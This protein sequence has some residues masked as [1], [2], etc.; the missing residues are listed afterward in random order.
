MILRLR[1]VTALFLITVLVSCSPSGTVVTEEI[2]E[3]NSISKFF[4]ESGIFSQSNTGFILYDPESGQ[5]IHEIGADR[6]Y[7]PA[8]NMKMFTL[9]AAAKSLPDTLPSLLYTVRNDSLF[10]HGTADPTFLNPDFE[11]NGVLEFLKA[12]KETLVYTDHLFADEHFGSGWSWDWYP[13]AYAPEKT[14]FPIY[15]NMMRMQA[16]QISLLMLDEHTP[17]KPKFF[18]RFIEN[19][20]WNGNQ[21]ELAK[22]DYQTNTIFYVPKSDTVA[23]VRNIPFKYES[24]FFAEMLS[25]TLGR[26]VVMVNDPFVT[27][28]D[29]LYATPADTLYRSMMINSDNFVA[30]QLMLMISLQQ[31]GKM[32][33]EEAISYSLRNYFDSLTSQ[34]QW[35]DGSGLT[36]YNLITP[37]GTVQLLEMII[38]KYGEVEAL[39][40]FP[41]GGVSGTIQSMYRAPVGEQPYVYAKTGT[42]S[43][44][45]ALSGYVFTDSGRRLSFSFINNNYV[46]SNFEIRS[47]MQKALEMIKEYY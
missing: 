29:T 10:F 6:F 5:T 17:V 19:E 21:N 16:R 33:T 15:G 3:D 41:A 20:G 39:S 30:E 31:T 11:P 32:N 35:R 4:D 2:E 14:P 23:Q 13:A 38:D 9:Y 43:N 26:D 36:R 22:R 27:F 8:S 28:T 1:Y 45:T 47:E 46:I 34:P 40:Y 24:E 12:R 44:N 7:I 25:D 37:R 42:L 18:E